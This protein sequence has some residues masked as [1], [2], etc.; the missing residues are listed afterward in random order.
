MHLSTAQ[1][2][3]AIDVTMLSHNFFI[4]LRHEAKSQKKMFPT[5]Q[6]QKKSMS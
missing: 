6:G 3:H 4:D 1:R 2:K 5:S